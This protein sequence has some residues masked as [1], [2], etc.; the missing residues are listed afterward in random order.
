MSTA[1]SRRASVRARACSAAVFFAATSAASSCAAISSQRTCA[2]AS[3]M[4]RDRSLF[5]IS[6]TM[7]NKASTAMPACAAGKPMVGGAAVVVLLLLLPSPSWCSARDVLGR[8]ECMGAEGV[9]DRTAPPTPAGDAAE[10]RSRRVIN[11]DDDE[12]PSSPCAVN[13]C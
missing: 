6:T 7:P 11:D 8:V 10:L 4:A 3:A 1:A 12:G 9:R 5:F 13:S 2:S